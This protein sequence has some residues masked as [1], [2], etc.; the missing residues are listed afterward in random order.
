MVYTLPE[1]NS[2]FALKMDGWHISF[3]LGWPIFRCELLVLERVLPLLYN[4]HHSAFMF[5]F[6]SIETF[7]I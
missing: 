1:T 7:D 3:L 4:K 6:F 2:K 5:L